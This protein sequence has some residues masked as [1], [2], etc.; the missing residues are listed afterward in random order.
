MYLPVWGCQLFVL[1]HYL[2]QPFGNGLACFGC[3]SPG[4]FNTMAANNYNGWL[5]K[6]QISKSHR[7]LA[8]IFGYEEI[9]VL[10]FGADW[11]GLR[12]HKATGAY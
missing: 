3:Q 7:T 5:N 4:F 9:H 12:R 6:A 8:Q 2:I 1:A 11:L 10:A